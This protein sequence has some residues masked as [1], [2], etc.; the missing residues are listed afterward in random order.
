[1][2]AACR[3]IVYFR[4]S[5]PFLHTMTTFRLIG[6]SVYD[7]FL[8]HESS[9]NFHVH[10]HLRCFVVGFCC[11]N[12]GVDAAVRIH[13]PLIFL[14]YFPGSPAVFPQDESAT[15]NFDGKLATVFLIGN[16]FGSPFSNCW[17]S[18][19]TLCTA[20]IYSTASESLT[21]RAWRQSVGVLT[22]PRL[23]HQ[24]FTL[25]PAKFICTSLAHSS[26]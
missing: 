21:C 25:L 20:H 8:S 19:F 11:S 16:L 12:G 6:P 1:M 17:Q 2:S 23:R 5:P 10:I 22:T 3:S 13:S 26:F 15:V 9:T 18:I 4:Q 7:K 24:P 14:V